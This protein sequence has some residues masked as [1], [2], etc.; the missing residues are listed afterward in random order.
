MRYLLINLFAVTLLLTGCKKEK[1]TNDKILEIIS[2]SL[3]ID[4]PFNKVII[5]QEH[6]CHVCN[7]KFANYILE[8]SENDSTLV[9]YSLSNIKAFVNDENKIDK[10]IID[11]RQLFYK[12][13]VL[14][15]SAVILLK[16]SKIDT[17]LNFS[18]ARVYDQNLDYLSSK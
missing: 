2:D 1:S 15:H 16:E 3:K 4:R 18:D 13:N 6:G 14:N 9:I 10:A 8:E 5:L 12:T 17:I 7:T 11:R